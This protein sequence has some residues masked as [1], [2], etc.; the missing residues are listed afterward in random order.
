MTTATVTETVV[1]P[2]GVTDEHLEYLDTLRATG[3]CNMFGS[4]EY[5]GLEFG[6]SRG[7]ART[8][9]MYWMKTF[10]KAFR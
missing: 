9:V 1:R 8:V 4:G 3:V 6:L 7:E 5:V 2:D 10:G